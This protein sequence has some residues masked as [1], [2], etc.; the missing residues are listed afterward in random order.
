MTPSPTERRI[1][2]DGEIFDVRVR[3]DQ[4]GCDFDWVSGPNHGYGF[5]I[6]QSVDAEPDGLSTSAVAPM[7]DQWTRAR[8]RDFL[9]QVDPTTGYIAD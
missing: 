1:A 2:V 4:L 3:Q 6:G 9:S 5:T 7:D 8:I